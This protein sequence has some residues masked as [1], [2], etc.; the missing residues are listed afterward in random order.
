MILQDE[1]KFTFKLP[2]GWSVL[3]PLTIDSDPQRHYNLYILGVDP[4]SSFGPGPSKIAV[5]DPQQWTLEA[6]AQVQSTTCPANPFEDVTLGGKPARRTQVGGGVVPC[7]RF[8]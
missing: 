3:G 7:I 4:S 5:L 1:G 6:F 8:E 2:E